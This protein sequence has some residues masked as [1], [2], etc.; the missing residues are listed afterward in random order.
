MAREN[1]LQKAK[2]FATEITILNAKENN[3]PSE[4]K[5][6]HSEI[7]RRRDKILAH[8][9]LDIFEPTYS[10]GIISQNIVYETQMLEKI[11]NIINLI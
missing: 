2:Y 8:K 7:I 4:Y 9:D 11:D 6:L 3:M 5:K 1:V 10:D